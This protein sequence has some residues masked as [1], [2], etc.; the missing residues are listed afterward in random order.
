VLQQIAI[1]YLIA[2]LVLHR[3]PGPQAAT[4]ALLL[5]L[6]TAAFLLFAQSHSIDPWQ[7]GDNVG[8]ALDAWLHLPFNKGG[9]VTLNAISSASTILFGVLGGE[10]LRCETGPARKL[11][12]LLV[13]GLGGLFAGSRLEPLVPMVKRLWTSSFTLYAAGWTCLMLAAF[14]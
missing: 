8:A 7:K 12:I 14:Y 2:F 3:G 11:L 5:V 1:G 4:A 6:H 13:A 10:L 9:Y